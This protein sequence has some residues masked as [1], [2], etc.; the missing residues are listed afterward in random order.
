MYRGVVLW[1]D[2]GDTNYIMV[3]IMV[4]GTSEEK[5]DQALHYLYVCTDPE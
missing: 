4:H 2:V 1:M 3:Q 5:L